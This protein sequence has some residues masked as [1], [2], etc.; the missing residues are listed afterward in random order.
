MKFLE[1]IPDDFFTGEALYETL[2]VSRGRVAFGPEHFAR[3]R[4]SADELGFP[5]PPADAE[6]LERLHAYFSAPGPGREIDVRL[7]LRLAHDSFWLA[8]RPVEPG[9]EVARQHGVPVLIY[10]LPDDRRAR[11]RHKWVER[12]ALEEARQAAREAGA[13]EALL[14]APDGCLLEGATSNVFTV[15]DGRL[16]TP[17]TDARILPGVTR[18]A[19]CRVAME[20][21]LEIDESPVSEGMLLA[22]DEVFLT[23][24]VRLLVPVVTIDG[25]PVGSGEPGAVARD[26]APRLWQMAF[27]GPD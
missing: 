24:A 20:S 19:L 15:I 2:L 18:S 6:I 12:Q 5:P 27:G 26:L 14:V 1:G 9:I 25:Q 22:A 23:S 11:A 16:R 3:L 13:H 7:N 10:R 17:P 21:G 4:A 8:V